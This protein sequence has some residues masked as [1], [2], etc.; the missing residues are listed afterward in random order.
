VVVQ[1]AGEKLVPQ[2]AQDLGQL[3]RAVRRRR[4]GDPLALSIVRAGANLELSIP[5]ER[6]RTAPE[7]AL[8]E[9]DPAFELLV[10]E[11]TFLDREERRWSDQEQGVLVQAVEP[12]G[13]AGLGGVRP[14]D[15]VEEVG[16]S[17]VAS[18]AAFRA[19]MAKV[20]KEKPARVD[21]VVRRG[22]RAQHLVLEPDWK[23][24][25]DTAP[26]AAEGDDQ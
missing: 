4:E 16:A 5:V 26:D 14:G 21:L 12:A 9:R 17:H 18:V 22:A 19:A 6:A 8:R 10:R 3:E 2:S 1:L 25:P 13:F 15:L 7:E 23:P 11:V 20:S 24:A